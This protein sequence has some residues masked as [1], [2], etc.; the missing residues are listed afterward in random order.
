MTPLFIWSTLKY[1]KMTPKALKTHKTSKKQTHNMYSQSY[2][3]YFEESN[4]EESY[5]H[6]WAM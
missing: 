5:S 2:P 6:S 3:C 1:H 4:F